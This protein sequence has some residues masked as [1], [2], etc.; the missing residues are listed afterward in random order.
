MKE[1]D[2][3]LVCSNEKKNKIRESRKNTSLKRSNQIVKVYE[4]K[5]NK[6]RL[7]N[8]QLKELNKL[9][10]EAK[11]FYN[12]ILAIHKSGIELKDINS[13]NI[14]EVKHFDKNK[15]EVITK[16]EQISSQQ[17]QA[18]I[19]RMISNE[20]TICSLV[21]RGIQKHGNLQ[22][23]SEI[24][25]IPLKQYG[26]SYKFKSNNKIKIQGI[27]GKI[28]VRGVKQFNKKKVE[29]ANANLI[30]KPDGYYLKI[31]C[32]F[33][34]KDLKQEK[35]TDKILGLDFGIKT[36]ITTSEGEKIDIS[37]E[38]SDQLKSL[39]KK[40]QRQKKGSNNRNKTIFK[41]RRFYQKQT[42]KKQDK[43]N[44]FIH[45]IKSYSKVIY[46]DEQLAKWHQ[47]SGMSKIIQH[48]CMG[49]I[50]SKLNYL[51]NTI[52]LD[53]F[54]PTTKWCPNC[55][56]VKSDLTLNDRLYNCHCGYSEDRDIHAAKN[57]IVIWKNL[58]ENNL[59]PM[60]GRE[61]KLEDWNK[62]LFQVD[63]RRC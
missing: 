6:K 32:Y 19:S 49:L 17:K 20:K 33:D 53:K 48:S 3:R 39:Q 60:D 28:L 56:S 13:T 54:I 57:M 58:V 24:N 2:N 59:V 35:K 25:C 55:K 16:L 46:Q 63:P 45:K 61:V 8:I 21:K 10:L 36:N 52:K 12:Q 23:K 40:L 27:S 47:Q 15:I 26:N 22:F 5:I 18:M 44:K 34:K 1:K 9:F 29:F 31:I 11:W 62:Y 30:K 50:K 37:I 4:L 7:K 14:K 43:A 51:D 38:E 42:Q 41:I